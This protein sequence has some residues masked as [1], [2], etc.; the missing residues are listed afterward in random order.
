MPFRHVLRHTLRH[1]PLR[2]RQPR[3]W[4]QTWPTAANLSPLNVDDR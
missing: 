2:R 3:P 1:V 4:L